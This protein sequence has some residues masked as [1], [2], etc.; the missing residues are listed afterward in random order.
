V[1]TQA[2][3]GGAAF[4]TGVVYNDSGITGTSRIVSGLLANTDY[5]WHVRAKNASGFSAYQDAPRRFT[6]GVV[7]AI[8]GDA[9]AVT[10]RVSQNGE[11]LRF[12]LPARERVSIRIYNARGALL[13]QLLDETREA[14]SHTLSLPKD[15]HGSFY[16]VDF[17]TGDF[18]QT[19]K[20][21]P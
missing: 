4:A 9:G 3:T 20:I 12:N 14:G 1:G 11:F 21:H 16:L 18:R 7:M 19:L 8:A 5:Y 2:S 10:R 17:K 15:L 13:T 6:S